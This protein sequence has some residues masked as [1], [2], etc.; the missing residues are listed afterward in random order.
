MSKRKKFKKRQPDPWLELAKIQLS[1]F[2]SQRSDKAQRRTDYKD[3]MNPKV[4]EVFKSYYGEAFSLS[5]AIRMAADLKRLS[6]E[7]QVEL[8]ALF[9]NAQGITTIFEEI[10]DQSKLETFLASNKPE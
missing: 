4:I 1:E 6:N 3:T 8:I 2:E 5:T 10:K 7:E 9:L